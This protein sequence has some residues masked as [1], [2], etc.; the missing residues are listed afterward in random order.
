MPSPEEPSYS[1]LKAQVAALQ[2]HNQQLQAKIQRLSSQQNAASPEKTP[3]DILY[4]TLFAA[5]PDGISILETDLTIRCTNNAIRQLHQH[6]SHLEG[7]KCY[8]AYQGRTSPCDHCPV[9]RTLATDDVAQQE[10]FVS[11]AG[12][13]GCWINLTTY[14]LRD[15]QG[16]INAIVEH[17]RD[18]SAQKQAQ[19]QRQLLQQAIE[20]AQ[21]AIVITDT[22][23]VIEY[24]NPAF[25][26]ISGYTTKEIMGE[27]PRLLQ[28]GYHDEAFYQQLW[29]Q[30]TQGHT[31]QGELINKRKDGALYT[32]EATISPVTDAS[33][34]IRN[35]VA[36]K[37]DITQ[38][39]IQEQKQA[40]VQQYYQQMFT[41]NAAPMLLIDPESGYIV[42]ANPAAQEF[43]GYSLK[44][45]CQRRIQD[46]NMLSAAETEAQMAKAYRDQCRF[47]KFRHQLANG[48]VRHVHVYSGPVQ[49]AAHSYLY[50]IVFDVTEAVDYQKRLETITESAQDG[51][52]MIDP[53]GKITF[54]NPAAEH[55]FGYSQEEVL[56]L[57]LH[58]LI[59]PANL[60]ENYRVAFEKFQQTGDGWA[61]GKTVELEACHRNGQEFPVELSL[62]AMKLED[63]WHA[64]GLIRDISDRKQAEAELQ[65]INAHL[66]EQTAH[67][68]HMAAQA[69]MANAA[70]SIFLANMS[71][72]IR[73]PMNGIIGMTDLLLDSGL[74][75]KQQHYAETIHSSAHSLLGLINDI[76]DFSKIEAQ[77]LDLEHI[78]FDLQQLL[79]DFAATLAFKAQ[80]KGLEFICWAEPQVPKQLQGDPGRLRQILNN[81]AT[82]A[83]KFTEQGHILIH[84]SLEADQGQKALI[85]FEVTDTGIGIAADKQ[86]GIF[87]QFTQVDVSTTRKYGGTGLG[88]AISKQLAQMMGGDIGLHSTP[89]QGST[90]WFTVCLPPQAQATEPALPASLHGARVLLLTAN[91]HMQNLLQ[92]YLQ[93]W[94]L[95]TSAVADA[96]SAFLQLTEAAAA[97]N[98]YHSIIA[99]D[100]PN[101][102]WTE[103]A[104][105]LGRAHDSQTPLPLMLLLP[106]GTHD[107]PEA[108][109]DYTPCVCLSKPVQK[110]Q[111]RQGLEQ[112]MGNNKH[113]TTQKP[114][115][116]TPAP[117]T[118]QGRVLLAEDNAT[119][120]KLALAILKKLGLQADAV[121]TG[122]AALQALHRVPYDLVLMDIQIPEMDGLEATRQLRDPASAVLD[123]KI[124]VI[125]MTAH[126]MQGD[127]QMCL[128]AGMN[129]YLAKP[130]QPQ[131]LRSL[132]H[133][134]LAP[135]KP[136]A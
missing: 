36:V 83:I 3:L 58:Q 38:R 122:Q 119:N 34:Q 92:A 108:L 53:A 17:V 79:D 134:Y 91:P 42:D 131:K 95:H 41:Q 25:E 98:P 61:V 112:L 14:P 127:R 65:D 16:H 49:V 66:Q 28:S 111:L 69:E 31:W 126:A 45:I 37:H 56:G 64:V 96:S 89:G 99:D 100:T 106:L 18:I 105:Q 11:Q 136:Q 20:Q 94:H 74:N 23:A 30:L 44:S 130:L 27:N 101:A 24:V 84:V 9:W 121:T 113:E 62:S 67:A 57:D 68:N 6:E 76:L 114:S 48:E 135:Q 21:E 32:E 116:T 73:T 128:D 124:P 93:S 102:P 90:F 43:Y 19:A 81:L 80:E 35:Y 54:W 78:A 40:E 39:K 5:M 22:E 117:L 71:H 115:S 4:Q 52:I 10:V 107:K 104:T 2:Q 129:D 109:A 12:K 125:A 1:Q 86:V 47:F 33:G 118:L 60:L 77:K 103:L 72:E 123:P 85:R 110:A 50:S 59:T 63:G 97:G 70:K 120:Q 7:R 26:H 55:I 132:L 29:R 75:E 133:Q 46:I 82:N 8:E 51:I 87:E 13:K 15:E 88:L